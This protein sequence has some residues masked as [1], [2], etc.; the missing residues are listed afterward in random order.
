MCDQKLI[1]VLRV[2]RGADLFERC[3][4]SLQDCYHFFDLVVISVNGIGSSRDLYQINKIC[5]DWPNK[6]VFRTNA[7]LSAQQHNVWL[8]NKLKDIVKPSDRILF[9]SHD[10]E[11]IGSELE[12]WIEHLSASPPEAAWVGDFFVVAQHARGDGKTICESALPSLENGK[13]ISLIEWL[14]INN[15]QVKKCVRTNISGLSVKFKVW[16]DVTRFRRCLGL[17]FGAR[18]EYMLLAH[19]SVRGVSKKQ[20]PMVKIWQH[21]LQQ[22]RN[23][24]PTEYTKDEIRYCLWLLLNSKSLKEFLWVSQSPW[25]IKSITKK[26]A[27][28]FYYQLKKIF[29]AGL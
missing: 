2:Y 7:E 12:K 19:R 22:G 15:A 26:S 4:Q 11:L 28:L 6:A 24:P 5:A 3:L 1:L 13:F 29:S 23:V 10:D 21:E 27:G 8:T 17:G 9:L 16:Y 20:P 25:G 14:E 18:Q